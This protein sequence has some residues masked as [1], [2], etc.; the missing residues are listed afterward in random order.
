[1]DSNGDMD[2]R[3]IYYGKAICDIVKSFFSTK[4]MLFII[5]IIY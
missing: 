3:L 5:I 2:K 4:T 1:M